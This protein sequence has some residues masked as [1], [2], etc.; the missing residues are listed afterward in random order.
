M[1]KIICSLVA[2]LFLTGTALAGSY[3]TFA[4]RNKEMALSLGIPT[5]GECIESPQGIYCLVEEWDAT[6]M[7]GLD[8]ALHGV[9]NESDGNLDG[10]VDLY[11]L[12]FIDLYGK[13]GHMPLQSHIIPHLKADL[14]KNGVVQHKTKPDIKNKRKVGGGPVI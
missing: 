11:V 3:I 13:F 12:V 6:P 8:S 9:D 14:R 1:K 5:L 4:E 7:T 2:G 10:E